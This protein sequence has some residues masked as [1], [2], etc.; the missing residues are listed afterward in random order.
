MAD[1]HLGNC[2]PLEGKESPERAKTQLG[3]QLACQLNDNFA[4]PA[5]SAVTMVALVPQHAHGEARHGERTFN[6]LERLAVIVHQPF[7][8]QGDKV[9]VDDDFRYE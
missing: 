8:H 1:E 9:R 4:Y 2:A 3:L 7:R 5:L 6:H